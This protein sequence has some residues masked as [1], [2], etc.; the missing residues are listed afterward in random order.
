MKQMS[1]FPRNRDR[2]TGGAMPVLLTTVSPVL[3]EYLTREAPHKYVLSEGM[4]KEG[5]Q[6]RAQLV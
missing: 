6:E 3:A 2:T 1:N 5:M 4:R